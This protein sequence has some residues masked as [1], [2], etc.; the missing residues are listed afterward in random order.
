MHEKWTDEMI[1]SGNDLKAGLIDIGLSLFLLI[2]YVA[3]R[4][5]WFWLDAYPSIQKIDSACLW[6]VPYLPCVVP[7][8]LT[9]G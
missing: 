4:A 1:G 6:Y 5:V 7:A 9:T 8:S 2:S 3:A